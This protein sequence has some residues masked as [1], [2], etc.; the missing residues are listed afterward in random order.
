MKSKKPNIEKFKKCIAYKGLTRWNSLPADLHS[1]TN[2][3]TFKMLFVKLVET[4][5]LLS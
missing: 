5:F 3:A 4:R 1:A 2:K